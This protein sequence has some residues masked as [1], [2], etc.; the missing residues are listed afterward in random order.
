MLIKNY[1]DTFKNFTTLSL[2]NVQKAFKFIKLSKLNLSLNCYTFFCHCSLIAL[3][4]NKYPIPT[5]FGFK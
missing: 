4:Y 5:N 3:C 1:I 2:W